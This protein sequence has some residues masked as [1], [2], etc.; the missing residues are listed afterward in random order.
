MICLSFQRPER[1]PMAE[2]WWH[3]ENFTSGTCQNSRKIGYPILRMTIDKRD[4][5]FLFSKPLKIK[6]IY[7]KED[8]VFGNSVELVRYTNGPKIKEGT[9]AGA[10]GLRPWLKRLFL[11]VCYL[12]TLYIYKKENSDCLFSVIINQKK[13]LLVCYLWQQETKKIFFLWSVSE[14]NKK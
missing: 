10:Y 7:G 2:M 9:V 8:C 3:L 6:L 14:K 4:T 13:N 1:Q 11:I 12:C 5:R